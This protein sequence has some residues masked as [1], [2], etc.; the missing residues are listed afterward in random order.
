MKDSTFKQL[1]T[2]YEK[3]TATAAERHV[4]EQWYASFDRTA[5]NEP[6]W[7]D[8]AEK[9]RTRDRIWQG[10]RGTGQHTRMRRL[11]PFVGWAAAAVA[12]LTVGLLLWK[13]AAERHP[14]AASQLAGNTTGQQIRTEGRQVKRVLL[15]DSSE[16]WLNANS[17]LTIPENYG[18][19]SRHLQLTG[20][21]FFDVSRDTTQPFIIASP[22]ITVTV[23]GTSFN[24]RAYEG[25]EE[26][27]VAVRTGRVN[28]SGADRST[29]AELTADDLLTYNRLSG[30]V[31]VGRADAT[32]SNAWRDGRSVF[33]NERFEALAQGFYNL[34]GVT[35][36]TD[37]PEVATL[38]YSLV[39]NHRMTEEEAINLICKVVNKHYRKEGNHR[40]VI[41]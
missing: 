33:E 15:P 7:A 3:G 20:E 10:A 23:L 37:D 9:I 31:T 38:R 35:L 17:S 32:R 2:K 11:R 12:V 8:E 22:D 6:L 24:V 40:V 27:Q 21:A 29:L 26:A 25:L 13:P 30:S 16:V 5:G 19:G 18:H 14:H 28:V 34:F 1:L 36:H 39:L 41:Y 4:V